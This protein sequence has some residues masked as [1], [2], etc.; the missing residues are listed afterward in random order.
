M[1]SLTDYIRV[2]DNVS[3]DDWILTEIQALGLQFKP[4]NPAFDLVGH[5]KYSFLRLEKYKNISNDTFEKLFGP[6][7][8]GLVQ[9][10][11]EYCVDIRECIYSG[12]NGSESFVL[13]RYNTGDYVMCHSDYF[14]LKPRSLSLHLTLNENFTGGELSFFNGQYIIQPKKNQL[15]I[16]PANFIFNY[17]ILPITSGERW[18]AENWTN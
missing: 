4:A 13:T 6:L 17:E 7:Q 12:L 16:F 1:K 2:F 10:F 5:G 18:A 15:V 11:D 8:M 3:V 14:P 9:A